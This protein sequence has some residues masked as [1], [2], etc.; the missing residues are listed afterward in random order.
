MEASYEKL[1]GKAVAIAKAAR[2]N[3]EDEEQADL[4]E[5]TMQFDVIKEKS[6]VKESTTEADVVKE[7]LVKQDQLRNSTTQV[8]VVKV[9]LE[10]QESA[11]Q[12]DVIKE[13]PADAKQTVIKAGEELQ[14]CDGAFPHEPGAVIEVSKVKEKLAKAEESGEI[15]ADGV[16]SSD[17]KAGLKLAPIVKDEVEEDCHESVPLHVDKQD[18]VEVEMSVSKPEEEKFYIKAAGVESADAKAELKLVSVVKDEV[19]ASKRSEPEDKMVRFEKNKEVEKDCH[20]K[21]PLHIDKQNKVE[22]EMSVSKLKEEKINIKAA[23][24]ES[25]Q[26]A[27]AGSE[28]APIV[29]DKVETSRISKAEAEVNI[30]M[31]KADVSK[32]VKQRTE[33]EKLLRLNQVEVLCLW[34]PVVLWPPDEVKL[35]ECSVKQGV[36]LKEEWLN[37]K[38]E[39]LHEL[40]PLEMDK[41][42]PP[43]RLTA[44]RA[45]LLGSEYPFEQ[46]C[47]G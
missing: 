39:V 12:V 17:A 22:V 28:M 45:T 10:E 7:K 6:K 43:A 31:E 32:K 38:E 42:L 46:Y 29:K 27:K 18:M 30:V 20:E 11:M 24:T 47:Q 8:D 26:G 16:E 25:S 41:L 15:K 34:L 5:S 3:V 9:R 35:K 14:K 44:E 2:K 36:I 23:Q 19:K 1:M 40:T 4:K 21:F 33:D 13:K 37:V